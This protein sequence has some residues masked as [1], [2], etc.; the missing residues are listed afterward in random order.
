[1]TTV[2]ELLTRN[3][4]PVTVKT[5][6]PKTEIL[7]VRNDTLHVALKAQPVEGKANEA[8]LKLLSKQTGKQCT[9]IAGAASKKKL[10]SCS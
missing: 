8:L 7:G 10:I 4:I 3:K 5:G 9:I 1:V 2:S 6:A